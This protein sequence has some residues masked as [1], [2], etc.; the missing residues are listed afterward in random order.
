MAIDVDSVPQANQPATHAEWSFAHL[1]RSE[2]LWGPHGYHRYPAKF[3]PQLVRRLIDDYSQSGDLVADPFLGS[4]TTGIEALRAGCRFYGSDI[5]PVAYL[6]SCAKCIP[7]PPERLDAVWQALDRQLDAVQSIGRR[8]LTRAEVE[9]IRATDIARA[10]P[11][12][13][14]EYWFPAGHRAALAAIVERIRPVEDADCRT[15][16]LCAFS[17]ILRQCSIWLS[18]STKPQKDLAK[19]L[20]D[21]REEFRKHARAMIK[22]NRLYWVDV[23]QSGINPA[24]LP[25]LCEIAVEDARSLPL[26]DGVVDLVVTSPPYATCYEYSQI[27]QL[28]QLW[29]ERYDLLPPPKPQHTWIG[30]KGLALRDST[31]AE[32]GSAIADAALQQLAQLQTAKRGAA[33]SREMRALRHYFQDMHRAL[34]ELARVLAPHKHLILIIGDSRKRGITIPTSDALVE[35][36][37]RQGFTLERTIVRQIPVR[38]LTSTRDSKTGRFSPSAQSDSQAYPEENILILRRRG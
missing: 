4:A 22:R 30:S 32:T 20:G 13:R 38:V 26:A 21:P 5:N 23:E 1:K 3:I 15:F 10:S 36:A 29:L 25:Q 11:E 6:I 8:T 31:S 33:V 19:M 28:T 9:C 37:Q 12:E 2:T 7:L 17:N 35:M 16:L 14:F 18:G 24:V 27:H 34:A